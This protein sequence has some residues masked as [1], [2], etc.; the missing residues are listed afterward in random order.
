MGSW[1]SYPSIFN[2]GHRAIK[3]LLNGYV[4]VEEKVDGS[5]FSFGLV[6]ASPAD[7]VHCEI[8]GVPYALKI[9][10]KGAVMHIDAP[11]RMFAQAAETVKTLANKLHPGWTYRGEFLAK[12][13][14]NSLA[15]D[16]TPKHHIILFDVSTGEQEYLNYDSKVSEGAR[17]GL[18]VVPRLFM[19]KITSVDEFRKFLGTVSVL[20]GQ[21]IEGVVVKPLNYDLYG[22]DKK[23]LMGKFVSEAFKE[24]HRK[25]WGE[26]NPTGKDIITRIGDQ[27]KT[28]ARWNKAIQH[29]RE[30]GKLEDSPRDI[31]P[32]IKEIPVDVLK[33]C[34]ADI[35]DELFKWAWPHIRRASTAGFPEYYKELLLKKSFENEAG[36]LLPD[37]G[38]TD[39]GTDATDFCDL[40]ADESSDSE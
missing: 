6:E 11:E 17:L 21:T 34:E 20:G 9:R 23:V 14:H 3:D 36:E 27:Y 25:I 26:S 29:L 40:V 28:P 8:V 1:S 18:E 22:T 12:P 10:S 31:G 30:A 38:Q 35:K 39:G 33:E 4:N 5:Q 37:G 2:M 13:K 32:L 16:R 19:G 24:V 15:Y 7:I